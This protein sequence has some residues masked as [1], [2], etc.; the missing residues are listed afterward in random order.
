MLQS[1]IRSSIDIAVDGLAAVLVRVADAALDAERRMI[2]RM[3]SF[4]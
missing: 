3:T 2:A 4:A 1:V